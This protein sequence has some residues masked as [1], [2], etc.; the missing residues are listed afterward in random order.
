MVWVNLQRKW[1]VVSICGVRCSFTLMHLVCRRDETIKDVLVQTL[2]VLLPLMIHTN[3]FCLVTSW[4]ANISEQKTDRKIS[5]EWLMVIWEIYFS[6]ISHSFPH[7]T[8]SKCEGIVRN[9]VNNWSFS[10]IVV[11]GVAKRGGYRYEDGTR[12]IGDWNSRGQKHGMGHLIL[13]GKKFY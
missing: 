12:Y 10:A 1:N 3:R 11:V 2:V 8:S 13:A 7:N 4:K 6:L 5:P 9:S